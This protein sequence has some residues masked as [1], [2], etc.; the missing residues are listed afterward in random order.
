MN[1]SIVILRAAGCFIELIHR[2]SNPTVWVV[3]QWKKS[4][5]FKT[6]I[7]S[8]WFIDAEQAMSFAKKMKRDH[9]TQGG[10]SVAKEILRRAK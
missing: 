1:E 4:L 9:D 7:S 2:N 5:W 6:L 8:D 3:R 10:S